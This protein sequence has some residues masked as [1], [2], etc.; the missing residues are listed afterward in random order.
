MD[1]FKRWRQPGDERQTQVPAMANEYIPYA[2]ATYRNAAVLVTKGDHIRLQDISIT[3]RMPRK[4][5][6]KLSLESVRL[7]GYIHNLG[8]LWKANG[9][10]IDPDYRTSEYISPRTT[11]LGIQID[12]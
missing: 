12:F 3:Y 4:W 1:Y 10:N 6:K 11:A 9:H 2:D 8:V 7:Y 5:I